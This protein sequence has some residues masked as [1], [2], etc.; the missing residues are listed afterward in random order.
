M[1]H[2]PYYQSQDF[3]DECRQDELPDV[4][5]DRKCDGCDDVVSES[6]MCRE[7]D[8]WFCAKCATPKTCIACGASV[9]FDEFEHI[10]MM[11]F[12]AVCAPEYR[13]LKVVCA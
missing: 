7:D 1:N 6:L 9:P 2:H 3:A 12:C 5:D 10:D 11:D 13:R 8:G 4:P